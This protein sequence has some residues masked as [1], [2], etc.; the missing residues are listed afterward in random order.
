MVK[1]NSEILTPSH[2]YLSFDFNTI[3][4]QISDTY[5]NVE[6]YGSIVLISKDAS[7]FSVNSYGK[8]E[9]FSSG[10]NKSDLNIIRNLFKQQIA[11]FNYN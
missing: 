6:D 1:V 9:F 2:I 3:K 11:G 10:I 8:M 4:K 5:N 7:F